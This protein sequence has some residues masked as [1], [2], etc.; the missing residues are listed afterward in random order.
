MYMYQYIPNNQTQR[1]MHDAFYKLL[2]S[3]STYMDSVVNSYP[4]GFIILIFFIDSAF[5]L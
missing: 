4:F 1:Y 2:E 5:G 3:Y